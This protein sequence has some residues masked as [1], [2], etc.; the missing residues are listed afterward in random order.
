LARFF[1]LPLE[2]KLLNSLRRAA[3]GPLGRAAALGTAAAAGKGVKLSN[4]ALAEY[5]AAI[6]GTIPAAKT[7]E[8][9]GSQENGAKDIGKRPDQENPPDQEQGEGG[10]GFSSGDHNEGRRRKGSC[11]DKRPDEEE[12]GG[13]RP[14]T[15]EEIRRRAGRILR[16]NPPL[17]LLNRIPG[18]NRRHWV[19]IPFS[20][21][22]G[23][24]EFTVSLRLSLGQASGLPKDPA[25][26]AAPE[27]LCADIRVSAPPESPLEGARRWVIVLEKTGAAGGAPPEFRAELS[28]FKIPPLP[29]LRGKPAVE[30][31]G[32]SAK[33]SGGLDGAP[34]GADDA[35]GGLVFSGAEKKRLQKELAGALDLPCHRVTIRD[36]TPLFEDSMDSTLQTVDEEV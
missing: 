22:A 9:A 21:T 5:A 32:E 26:T 8:G 12:G 16:E 7:V 30:S 2:P 35:L 13:L 11:D 36:G 29:P 3:L 1:S 20:F 19:L 34:K 14:P 6:E 31:S 27:R 15:E 17:D 28:L 23:D 33:H 24:R 25:K 4:R 18:K 10:G